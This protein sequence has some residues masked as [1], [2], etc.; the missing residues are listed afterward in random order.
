MAYVGDYVIV[1]LKISR[2]V[3]VA[4]TSAG[5]KRAFDEECKGMD[6]I[7]AVGDILGDR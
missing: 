7:G 6:T 4:E 3:R 1:V 5:K 2:L